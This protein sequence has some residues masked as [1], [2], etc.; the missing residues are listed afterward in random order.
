[1]LVHRVILCNEFR[2]LG[3]Y[4]VMADLPNP[5]MR[6]QF[7]SVF[8]DYPTTI[9]I[10]IIIGESEIRQ[11]MLTVKDV[12]EKSQYCMAKHEIYQFLKNKLK[13]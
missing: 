13:K 6:S 4:T 12:N 10:M 1:M 3:Y 8:E 9:P 2:K 5:K 11:N 7:A